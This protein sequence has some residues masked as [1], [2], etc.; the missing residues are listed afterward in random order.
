MFNKKMLW[1]TLDYR[2]IKGSPVIQ[3]FEHMNAAFQA[4]YADV[5]KLFKDLDVLHQ[6]LKQKIDS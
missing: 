3:D 1:I 2:A 5:C 6:S 4:T